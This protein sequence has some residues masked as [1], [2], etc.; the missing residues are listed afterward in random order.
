MLVPCAVSF[1]ILN[2]SLHQTPLCP[3]GQIL[4]AVHCI[5]TACKC[6]IRLSAL[7]DWTGG[8]ANP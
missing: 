4:H 7:P 2:M 8:G 6:T 5:H 1:S 3:A